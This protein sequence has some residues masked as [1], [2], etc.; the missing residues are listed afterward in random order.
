MAE[1]ERKKKTSLVEINFL[2]TMSIQEARK[3]MNEGG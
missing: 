2:S 3:I 1:Q